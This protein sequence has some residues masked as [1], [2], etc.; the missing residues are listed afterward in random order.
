MKQTFITLAGIVALSSTSVS[1]QQIRP[2]KLPAYRTQSE[3][4]LSIERNKTPHFS[5][6]LTKSSVLPDNIRYPG[7]FEESQ[8]VLIAWSY[9]YDNNGNRVSVDVGSDYA[10]VSARLAN[11]IQKVVPVIIQIDDYSDSI[12]IKNFMQ[13]RGTP[14]TNYKF[15]EAI[16]DDWWIRDY[17]PNGVYFGANDSLAFIDVKYYAGRDNDDVFPIAYAQHIGVPNYVSTLQTEGGNLM[18][19]GFG[20]VFMSDVVT[21]VNTSRDYRNP[22]WTKQQTLDTTSALFGAKQLF[23]L[24]TLRCDGGTGHIDL[25]IKMIDEQTIIAAKYPDE[26][27]ASDKKTI[28][29][30]LQYIASYNSTYNRPYRVYRIPHPTDDEG[31]HSRKTCAQINADARTFVNGLTINDTYIMPSYSDAM[32]GNKQQTDEV[33]Q[34]FR[35]L[36]PGYKVVDIDSRLL[37]ELGGELH[38]ISMQVPVENPVLF[39]H[40]SV[41]GLY[42]AV[43]NSFHIIA[44]IKNKS[45]IQS[46]KCM[47]R[48]KGQTNFQTI[49]LSDSNGY[50]IGD[51]HAN[52]LTVNDEI[53]YYLTATSNNGKTATKPLTAN[54]G[55]Y[56]NIRFKPRTGVDDHIVNTKNYLFNAYPSPAS[57]QITIPFYT[58]TKGQAQITIVDITGKEVK[59]I[60]ILAHTGL[61][62]TTIAIDELNNGIYF[63]TY[64]LDGNVIA[65]RKFLK[66][67]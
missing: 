37:S 42:P 52:N 63:Y 45:G 34:L 53:E 17:G 43:K 3:I 22:V 12:L 33:K 50:F 16:G 36:M 8:N 15:F 55:G 29:D 67:N 48:V 19:D 39:W 44:Q 1:A 9:N 28:E 41:D 62:E 10:V 40:P 5:Q 59:R 14:L 54:N 21:T 46:A 58:E 4:Q 56:Y 51:I 23:N 26:I 2:K 47:W 27:T 11:E 61:N 30:N 18:A 49:N 7:E 60:E 66:N 57:T 20:G 35:N 24:K 64:M 31:N 65:T 38:C 32:S 25:Y 6:V 13:Q